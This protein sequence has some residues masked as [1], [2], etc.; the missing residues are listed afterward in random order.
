MIC[1]PH[2]AIWNGEGG[3]DVDDA[4]VSYLEGGGG[5]AQMWMMPKLAIWT[6]GQLMWMMLQHLHSNK[7]MMILM[8]MI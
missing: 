4:P 1:M 5:G 6:G 8:V 3:T 2:L 7:N